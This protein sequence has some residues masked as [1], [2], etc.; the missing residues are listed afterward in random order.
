[1][2]KDEKYKKKKS[3]FLSMLLSTGRDQ[4]QEFIKNKGRD[5]EIARPFICLDMRINE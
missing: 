5:S 4:L 2:K 1:M 3:E